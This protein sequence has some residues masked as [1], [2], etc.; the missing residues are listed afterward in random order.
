MSARMSWG[1]LVLGLALLLPAAWSWAADAWPAANSRR[2]G[3][4]QVPVPKVLGLPEATA[5]AE[6]SR[7]G[8]RGRVH[9]EAGACQDPGS[10]GLVMRQRPEPGLGLPPNSWVD[11]TICP[12]LAPGRRVEVPHLIG[13]E[14]A[15]AKATLKAAGLGMR[16]T[17]R[18]KCQRQDLMGRVVQQSPAA[19]QQARRG[20]G[21]A[22]KICRGH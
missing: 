7:A 6:L 1:L 17:R 19:G 3:Q 5:R 18:A 2:L 10:V 16:V 4:V 21:V 11:I 12:E 13:L 15:Q 9:Q 8:L 14:E 20:Q 22:V